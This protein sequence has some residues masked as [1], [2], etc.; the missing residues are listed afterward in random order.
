MSKVK[1]CPFQ[2]QE[3]TVTVTSLKTVESDV[4]SHSQFCPLDLNMLIC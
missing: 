3:N 4:S 1:R 2:G